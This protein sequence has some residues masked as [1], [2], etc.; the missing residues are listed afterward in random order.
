VLSDLNMPFD[1]VTY[2]DGQLLATADLRDDQRR[3]VRFRRLHVRYMHETWGIALGLKVVA[4]LDNSAVVVAPGYAVDADGRDIVLARAARVPVPEEVGPQRFVLTLSYQEDAAYRTMA[5]LTGLCLGSD[6]DLRR[7]QPVVTWRRPEDVRFGPQ[8]PLVQ[9]GVAQGTIQGALD[10]R[11]RRYARPL[12]RP[13]AGWGASELGRT[14]WQDWQDG[15]QQAL[16][17]ETVVDT[18]EAGFTKTPYY[19]VLLQGDFSNKKGE[20]IATLDYWPA[21]TEPAFFGPPA[22][23]ISA[24]A[25]DSFTYRLIGGTFPFGTPAT[26]NQAEQRGWRIFWLGLEPVGGCAPVLDPTQIISLT[27]LLI[28]S[29]TNGA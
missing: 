23:F 8:V 15:G 6:A 16:G 19:F 28:L 3:A 2:H 25:R 24:A 1:R 20:P 13:H 4:A 18:A 11:V 10:F 9:V 5:D 14:G 17:L 26:A 29:T 21:G 27:D 22:G 12:V 7:E